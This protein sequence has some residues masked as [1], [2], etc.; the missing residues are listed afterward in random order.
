M[1]K[2]CVDDGNHMWTDINIYVHKF[3]TSAFQDN[4]SEGRTK[5]EM[6][7]SRPLSL[8]LKV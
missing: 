8:L 3:V 4:F 2:C 6:W 5:Q 7:Q 1:L